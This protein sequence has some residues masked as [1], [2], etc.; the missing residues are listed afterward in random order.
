M[1]AE[2]QS[3]KMA[4]DMEGVVL[5][6]SVQKKI[7]STDIHQFLLNIYENQTVDVS[8]VRLW[9]VHF[10]N[11]TITPA[12]KLWI[13]CTDADFCECVMQALVHH[14]KKYIANGGDYVEK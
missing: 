11:N 14:C 10:S 3:D 8:T 2:V 6:S 13:M 9:V 5:I 4:S 12:V 1:A 7:A